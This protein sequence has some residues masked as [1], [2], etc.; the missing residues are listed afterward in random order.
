VLRSDSNADGGG[1]A[2]PQD[3]DI[4]CLANVNILLTALDDL[5]ALDDAQARH[6]SSCQSCRAKV[7]R[8]RHLLGDIAAQ[9][10]ETSP[11]SPS[12]REAGPCLG[13]D[14]LAQLVD[15]EHTTERVEHLAHLAV[16]ARCRE[17]LTALAA[18]LADNDVAAE[19]RS[20]EASTRAAAKGR[21]RTIGQRAFGVL[22]AAAVVLLFA[23]PIGE[24]LGVNGHRGPTATPTITASDAPELLSPVEN[25]DVPLTFRWKAVPGSDR[26]RLTMFDASGQVVYGAT[27]ADTIL[28]LPDSVATVPGA[29]YLWKIEARTDVDR[30]TPSELTEFRI[31][32]RA[33]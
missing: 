25:S 11:P 6:V 12:S 16:C 8:M 18:L 1:S 32:P 28:V 30:W 17:E 2:T 20:V 9:S 21:R 31:V 4:P 13:E 19:V 14:L 26:Y 15:G 22:A 5:R 33:K 7:A 24:R 3:E 23:R 29:T 10:A 27:V